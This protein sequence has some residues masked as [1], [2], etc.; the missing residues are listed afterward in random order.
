MTTGQATNSSQRAE[1]SQTGS[2][3]VE[4]KR[5]PSTEGGNWINVEIKKQD[6]STKRGLKRKM[7][8]ILG[9]GFNITGGTDNP[10]IPGYSDVF[11]S[12][13]RENTPAY[14]NGKINVGDRIVS[15]SL[16]I[17]VSYI[18]SK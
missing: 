2:P 5:V 12:L 10:H 8:V 18:L 11:V 15:V 7:F 17:E 16:H 9:F 3:T 14:Y 13:I 1:S 4:L 6:G